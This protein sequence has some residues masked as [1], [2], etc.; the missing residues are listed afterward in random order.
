VALRDF[1]TFVQSVVLENGKQTH[2]SGYF[3]VAPQ[4]KIALT[5]G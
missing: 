2:P 4:I 1:D 3:N 5:N